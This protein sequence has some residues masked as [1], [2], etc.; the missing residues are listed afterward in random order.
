MLY[1]VKRFL[2]NI[3]GSPEPT[4][5]EVKPFKIEHEWPF[6]SPKPLNEGYLV[7]ELIKGIQVEGDHVFFFWGGEKRRHIRTPEGRETM[8]ARNIIWWMEGRKVPIT[9]AGTGLKTTCGEPKC[10]KLS[11][12]SLKVRTTVHGPK[13]RVIPPARQVPK[14]K[15]PPLPPKIHRGPRTPLAKFTKEDR[16]KCDTRKGYFAD[17]KSG[18]EYARQVNRPENRGKEPRQYVYPCTQCDGFHLTK[19]NPEKYGKK[20]VGSW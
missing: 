10:V 19:I 1:S 6:P 8:L 7:G 18:D 11:H 5:P 13:N 4:V 3:F 17:R 2:K 9:A 15:Q 16:M 14:D 12:L 20:K